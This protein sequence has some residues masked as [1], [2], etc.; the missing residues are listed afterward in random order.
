[1]KNVLCITCYDEVANFDDSGKLN[2]MNYTESDEY[3]NNLSKIIS[4]TILE[5]NIGENTIE[6][7]E[8]DYYYTIVDEDDNELVRNKDFDKIKKELSIHDWNDYYSGSYWVMIYC[9]FKIKFNE[10]NVTDEDIKKVKYFI[11]RNT[12]IMEE[13]FEEINE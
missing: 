3:F 13:N 5:N 2:E 6:C 9:T 12:D 11:T 10:S 8:S 4:K 7:I 1:M